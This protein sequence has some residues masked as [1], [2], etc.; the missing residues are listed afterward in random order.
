MVFCKKKKSVSEQ[1]FEKELGT[2][3]I[4]TAIDTPTRL[5]VCFLIGDR[6]LEDAR[7]F[8]KDLV[9]RTKE[10]P[11]FT[12]DELPHYADGLKELFHKLIAQK[13]TGQPGRP[14]NPEKVIDEDLD[15]ATVHKTR[16][17]GRI[18]KV[19]TKVVFGSSARIEKRLEEL[20][21]KTINTSYVERS[22]LN[23]RMWDAHLTRKSLMF[24]KSCRW[25]KAKFAICVG[26]YNFIRP[27]ET[28]SRGEDRV[29]RPN[30]PAMAAGITDH[31]WT[32]KTLLLHRATVN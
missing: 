9:S 20:P 5:I 22:N 26:F 3:W 28:L 19:E 23:W 13:A 8:L 14:R 2:K 24:A 30:T 4:W 15:Y 18:V 17:K 10:Q 1:E 6:T 21:G 31:Q 27:H 29:F 32:I 11:L 7:R 25:L 16:V 12:S